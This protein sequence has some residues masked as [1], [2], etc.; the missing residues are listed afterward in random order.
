[1]PV[2]VS[3][4]LV[5]QPDCLSPK[6]FFKR[7]LFENWSFRTTLL[8]QLVVFYRKP[9]GNGSCQKLYSG[10]LLSLRMCIMQLDEKTKNEILEMTEPIIAS[11]AAGA[12]VA[13]LTSAIEALLVTNYEKSSL[14]GDEG[15]HPT[16]DD[17]AISKSEVAGS[18]TEG[19][20]S[21]DKVAAEN[22]EI[23]A[24]ETEARALTGEVTASESGASAVRSKAGASDIETK[25]LKIT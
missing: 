3:I 11:A 8:P 24:N 9:P 25:A 12:V 22:G 14:T 13:A 18:E 1:M 23:K 21:Q 5:R 6:S 16:S 19:K 15:V 2:K 17:T 10:K 4:G 20:L 7:K